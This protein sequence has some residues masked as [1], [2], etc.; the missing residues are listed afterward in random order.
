[1]LICGIDTETTGLDPQNDRVIEIGAVLWESTTNSPKKILSQLVKST[2]SLNPEAQKVNGIT[3]EDLELYG[4]APATAA[5][6]LTEI[7]Q[8]ADYIMGHNCKKF[9]IPFLTA[10]FDK[11]G[12]KF[13]SLPVID[14]LTDI[15][16]D[17]GDLSRRLSHIAAA[18]GIINP[19]PHRA[20]FD[21]FTMLK[22]ASMHNIDEIIKRAITPSKIVKAIVTYDHRHLAKE[23]GFHWDGK[24]WIKEIKNDDVEQYPFPTVVV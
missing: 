3:K 13:P 12:F 16:Y 23:N 2:L 5:L 20:V 10:E 14:T 9:D 4:V 18:H 11:V 17:H 7:M 19:F 21:V 15:K 24:S 1:M 22:V 8:T 6:C